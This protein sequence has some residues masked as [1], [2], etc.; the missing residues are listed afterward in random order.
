MAKGTKSV[1][2]DQMLHENQ[3]DVKK[4][5]KDHTLEWIDPRINGFKRNPK[6]KLEV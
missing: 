6:I 1:L 2:K 4:K 3:N 5:Y